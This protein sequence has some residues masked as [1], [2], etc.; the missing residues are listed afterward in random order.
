M[1]TVENLSV[2]FPCLET[3]SGAPRPLARTTG[4][5]WPAQASLHASTGFVSSCPSPHFPCYNYLS[6][7]RCLGTTVAA[8]D[9]GFFLSLMNE[10]QS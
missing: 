9:K 4:S 10:V 5:M 8:Q 3:L 2:L 7:C 1:L 6:E